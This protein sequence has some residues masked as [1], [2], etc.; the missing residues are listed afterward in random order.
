MIQAHFRKILAAIAVV[1]FLATVPLAGTRPTG[2]DRVGQTA[3]II[4]IYCEQPGRLF[5]KGPHIHYGDNPFNLEFTVFEWVQGHIAR[6]VNPSCDAVEP[7]AKIVHMASGAAAVYAAGLLAAFLVGIVAS[8]PTGALAQVLGGVL[9]A[10]LLASDGLW[11]RYATYTMIDERVIALAL[12]AI[13]AALQRRA[14]L[15][16]PLWLLVILQRPQV[17]AFAGAF[18]AATEFLMLA[19]AR[20]EE[21]SF[22]RHLRE[23]APTLASLAAVALCGAFYFQWSSAMNAQSDL[24]WIQ[25]MGPRSRKWFMGDW[26]DRFTFAFY[27]NLII[28]WL[29]RSSLYA[30]LIAVAMAFVVRHLAAM[31]LRS[32]ERLKESV[33]EVLAVAFPYFCALF[34]Y[35]FVFYAVFIVHEYYALPVN[36]GRA[37]TAGAVLG[38]GAVE[39][40][41]AALSNRAWA[42]FT[43]AL[44][45][46]VVAWPAAQGLR[47]YAAFATHIEDF[48]S[49]GYLGDWN[50]QVFP[51]ERSMVVMAVPNSGR[52]L[53]QLYMT[54][55]RGF[56][57]CTQNAKFA[58]RKFWKD[59]GVEY[60]AWHDG[61]DAAAKR[62]KWIVRTIDEELAYA[63]ARPGWSS[64]VNDVWAGR[65]MA[66]WAAL[67]SRNF[68]DPCLYEKDYD[69][70]T[71]KDG[72][73]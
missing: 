21:R 73:P 58:P 51:K 14:L 15:S 72:S 30:G 19:R 26:G 8:G 23:A 32:K 5:F 39:L 2:G 45:A 62:T 34:G 22:R 6:A 27:K 35:T 65:T 69:P 64:D 52:E 12:F 24:P 49:P 57:W 7:V 63:R 67:G 16:F 44:L 55:Q 33:L 13:L 66:E 42:S 60:V 61:F 9:A 37:V 48:K 1:F 53:Y 4:R 10:L 20:R 17:F 28:E 59:H 71:W 31:N 50:V 43:A 3:G 38:L 36:A 46:A 40:L 70:R 11:L 25:W 54:K 29:R 68:L 47:H 56:A 41:L 18:W